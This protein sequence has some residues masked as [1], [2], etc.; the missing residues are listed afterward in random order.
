M[1]L[2]LIL[3]LTPE[4]P[5]FGSVGKI[6]RWAAAGIPLLFIIFLVPGIVF[7]VKAGTIESHRDVAR[8]MGDTIASLAPISYWHFLPHSLLKHL[9]I[10]I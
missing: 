8:M 2:F 10:L 9:N 4:A 6:P 7:G 1:G 3:I 5:L